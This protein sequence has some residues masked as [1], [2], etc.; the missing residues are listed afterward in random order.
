MINYL[1]FIDIIYSLLLYVLVK[2]RKIFILF[3]IIINIQILLGYFNFKY[4]LIPYMW[5]ASGYI[6]Y[7]K[8]IY[9]YYFKDLQQIPSSSYSYIS[10]GYLLLPIQFFDGNDFI[11][12]SFLNIFFSNLSVLF[13][14]KIFKYNSCN[15]LYIIAFIS[16]LPTHLLMS[17][18]V[19]REPFI[20]LLGSIVLYFTYIMYTKRKIL[21]PLLTIILT[22]YLLVFFRAFYILPF[23]IAFPFILFKPKKI[24]L[25]IILVLIVFTIMVEFLYPNYIE[26][27]NK[28]MEYRTSGGAA[29]LEGMNYKNIIDLFLFAPIRLVYFTFGPMPWDIHNLPALFTFIENLFLLYIAIYFLYNFRKFKKFLYLNRFY[30]FLFIYMLFGL[31]L[32]SMIDSNYGTAMRHKLQFTVL[33]FVIY[34]VFKDFLQVRRKCVV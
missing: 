17:V 30:L 27:I 8:N 25:L 34:F 2:E 24:L 28:S 14:Y 13:L 26:V 15:K 20:W 18:M 33:F 11:K 32:T 5:D 1:F 3:F 16:L 22:L 9:E 7:S 6:E 29:Y 31:T 10:M 4:N 12:A 19:T 23:L 21:F